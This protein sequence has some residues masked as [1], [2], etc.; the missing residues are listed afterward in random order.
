MSTSPPRPILMIDYAIT[1]HSSDRSGISI[2]T[3]VAVIGC[4]A[5]FPTIWRLW[6]FAKWIKRRCGSRRTERNISLHRNRRAEADNYIAM[7]NLRDRRDESECPE[8]SSRGVTPNEV[9]GSQAGPLEMDASQTHLPA[10]GPPSAGP[11]SIIPTSPGPSSAGSSSAG[12]SSTRPT[13][14]GPS[15]AGS[16]S[17]GPSAGPFSTRASS[18]GPSTS[19]ALDGNPLAEPRARAWSFV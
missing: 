2:V 8:P 9:E 1:K 17:A 5:F 15:S 13:S 16:S 14:A 11:S 6:V 18:A 10:A 12:P 19:R 7:D 4:L 3:L